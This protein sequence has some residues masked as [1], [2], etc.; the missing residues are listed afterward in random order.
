VSPEQAALLEKARASI[1]AARLLAGEHLH[2]F[3]V[4]RA[5][6]AMFYLAQ[7]LLL[8]EGLAFSKHSAV[9]AAFGR[10]LVKRGRLDAELHLYLR[11]AQDQRNR[12]DYGTGDPLGAEESA[13]QTRRAEAFLSATERILREP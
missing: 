9:I 1:R 13:E 10:H 4:S 3:A 8:G 11:E 5:Y 6:Y 7:A 12:G 2:D